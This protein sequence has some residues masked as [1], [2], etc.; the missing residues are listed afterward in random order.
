MAEVHERG[1][2]GEALAVEYLQRRGWTIL[3]R[4]WRDGPRELDV[5]AAREGVL[6]FVEVKGRAASSLASPFEAITPRKR[7][8]IERAARAWL[9]GR[10]TEATPFRVV[11]FDAVAV[12]FRR[13]GAVAVE[14][15]EDAWR[16]GDP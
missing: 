13:E 8:E 15:L 1:R 2:R 6:A 7:R 5:V 10:A 4:N 3:A 16:P 12:V 11:R 14:H 9:A